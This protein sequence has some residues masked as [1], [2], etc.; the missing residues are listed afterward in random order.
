MQ[1]LFNQFLPLQCPGV[2]LATQ[3]QPF[4]TISRIDPPD[5]NVPSEMQPA[6]FILSD[7]EDVDQTTWDQTR[8]QMKVRFVVMGW[9][10]DAANTIPDTVLN[11][12]VDAVDY[13][14]KSVPGM[15]ILNIDP[16]TGFA[17]PAN[18]ISAH[19]LPQT[20]GGYVV[21]AYLRGPIR[22]FARRLAQ[23]TWA[24]GQIIVVTGE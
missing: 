21:N 14:V 22:K 17:V 18:P 1:A 2:G 8:Y 24:A 13:A 5:P 6:L 23:Q 10:S 19:G 15:T 12:L 20:L 9:I 3:V 7:N 11:P 4:V 16:T